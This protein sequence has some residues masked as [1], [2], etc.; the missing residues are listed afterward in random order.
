MRR[1]FILSLL[2]ILAAPAVFTVPPP[3]PG[4]VVYV[5]FPVAVGAG[6]MPDWGALPVYTVTTGPKVSADPDENGSFDFSLASDGAYLYLRF[7][8]KDRT[9]VAGRHGGDFWNEDSLEFYINDSGDLNATVY[10]PGIFQ[11]NVNAA[12]LDSGGFDLTGKGLESDRPDITGRTFRT[13]DG[14]GF[15]AALSLAGRPE[16]VHGGAFGFQ[17]QANGASE[18][19]RDVKLIW[20]AF[21]TKDSSWQ[22][23][24]LFG[25]AVWYEI[26][27]DDVPPPPDRKAPAAARVV[28]P[29]EN[30]S[31]IR[32]NQHA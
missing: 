17:A 31:T 16:P 11:A 2:L 20:S 4:E 10:G 27:R 30:R 23:P 7:T 9:I 1:A 15:E 24:S 5:P 22:S 29:V 21:D 32:I 26:G 3:I 25:S 6:G 12:A 13:G 28:V 8:M 18:Y 19:D 14:W